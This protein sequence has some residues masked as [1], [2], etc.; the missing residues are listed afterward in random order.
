[1]R[2]YGTNYQK[3][4]KMTKKFG[5]IRSKIHKKRKEKLTKSGFFSKTKTET[6]ATKT[7]MKKN[8]QSNLVNYPHFPYV[9]I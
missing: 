1:M 4:S 9:K 8:L 6:Q 5:N 2:L 7:R 3:K